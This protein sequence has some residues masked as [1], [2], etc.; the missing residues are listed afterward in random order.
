M[1]RH[2]VPER[3]DRNPKTSAQ[4]ALRSA[5]SAG[6]EVQ[7]KLINR[8]NPSLVGGKEEAPQ[9]SAEEIVTLRSLL[10]GL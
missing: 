6:Q 3:Q 4:G 8:T 5:Q 7:Q 1:E 10:K 9:L 2:E